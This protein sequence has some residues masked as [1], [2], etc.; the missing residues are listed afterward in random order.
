MHNFLDKTMH[1]LWG[2]NIEILAV[3]NMKYYLE[4]I[5]KD[6]LYFQFM[7]NLCQHKIKFRAA[8]EINLPS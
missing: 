5:F 2:S 3:P 7:K 8:I 1:R 6:F 4:G